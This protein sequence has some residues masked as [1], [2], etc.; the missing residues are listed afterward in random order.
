VVVVVEVV[1]VGVEVVVV[2]LGRVV[3]VTCA[4]WV[5]GVRTTGLMGWL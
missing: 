2:V 1:V 5:W 4:T 3:V